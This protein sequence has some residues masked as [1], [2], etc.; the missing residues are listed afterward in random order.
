[1]VRLTIDVAKE[2]K[3]DL[4]V[5]DLV[6]NKAVLQNL[7]DI[8]M[9]WIIGNGRICAI[10]PNRFVYAVIEVKSLKNEPVTVNKIDELQTLLKSKTIVKAKFSNTSGFIVVKRPIELKKRIPQ[11]KS[12]KDIKDNEKW[13]DTM[14]RLERSEKSFKD[15]KGNVQVVSR[16]HVD[17]LKFKDVLFHVGESE[18]TELTIGSKLTGYNHKTRATASIP[19]I[20]ATEKVKLYLGKEARSFLDGALNLGE[21][22]EIVIANK[23]LMLVINKCKTLIAGSLE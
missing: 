21:R 14:F 6:E 22:S 10:H 13:I 4:F 19:K 12:K 2:R 3:V 11:L 8:S 5:L 17:N 20:N 9:D 7:M 18:K 15:N 23:V 16:F 1:M